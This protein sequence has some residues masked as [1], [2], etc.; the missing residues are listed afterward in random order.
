MR[1]LCAQQQTDVLA[2]GLSANVRYD[3]IPRIGLAASVRHA[4]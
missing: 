2:V 4:H 1:L 3:I